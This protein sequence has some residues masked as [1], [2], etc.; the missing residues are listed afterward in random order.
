MSGDRSNFST[1]D[2]R[3]PHHTQGAVV[4]SIQRSEEPGRNGVRRLE[5]PRR[6]DAAAS[7]TKLCQDTVTRF[8][9]VFKDLAVVRDLYLRIAQVIPTST[10]GP[11]LTVANV[12]RSMSCPCCTK[13]RRIGCKLTLRENEGWNISDSGAD[14]TVLA[15]HAWRREVTHP[16]IANLIGFEPNAVRQGLPTVTASS[17]VRTADGKDILVRIHHAV[18]NENAKTSLISEYQV[19]HNDIVWDPIATTQRINLRGDTGTCSFYLGDKNEHQVL[20]TILNALTTFKSRRPTE[21]E[22]DTLPCFELTSPQ[23]WQP[24]MYNKAHPIFAVHLHALRMILKSSTEFNRSTVDIPTI[25]DHADDDNLTF[26]DAEDELIH[27]YDAEEDPFMEQHDDNEARQMVDPPAPAEVQ[28]AN[29]ADTRSTNLASTC[30]PGPS[31]A[32]NSKSDGSSTTSASSRRGRKPA[33]KKAGKDAK[34][35]RHHQNTN[36]KLPP[37]KTPSRDRSTSRSTSRSRSRSQGRNHPRTRWYSDEWIDFHDARSGDEEAWALT[38]TSNFSV[39]KSHSRGVFTEKPLKYYDT[40]ETIK[41]MRGRVVHLTLHKEGIVNGERPTHVRS[42]DVNAF[43]D[44][45]AMGELI[46]YH[47]INRLRNAVVDQAVASLAEEHPEM[48]RVVDHFV[49]AART[50]NTRWENFDANRLQLQFGT[51]N[52]DRIKK[53]FR[54]TTQDAVVIHTVPMMRGIAA[55]FRWLRYPRLRETICTDDIPAPTLTPK[56]YK[57]VVAFFGERSKMLNIYPY[58]Q[59]SNFAE[60]YK[61]F[62]KD[63]GIPSSLHSDNA[64]HLTGRIIQQLNRDWWTKASTTEPHHPWQNP[65][66]T[67]IVDRMKKFGDLVMDASGAPK[68]VWF[69]AWNLFAY[70]NNRI[71]QPALNDKTPIEKRH[72]QIPDISALLEFTFFEPVYYLERSGRPN[73]QEKAGY[74]LGPV[75][76][77]GDG[78]VYYIM[79]AD[80]DDIVLA[81]SVVRRVRSRVNQRA[82]HDPP[83]PD[84]TPAADEEIPDE[85]KRRLQELEKMFEEGDIP[86]EEVANHPPAD[87]SPPQTTTRREL[88]PDPEAPVPVTL[89]HTPTDTPVQAPPADVPPTLTSQSAT[90]RSL[91]R[92]FRSR[93]QPSRVRSEPGR[94]HPFLTING[95]RLRRPI[96]SDTSLPSQV[97]PL[98]VFRTAKHKKRSGHP[99]DQTP[100]TAAETSTS[101]PQGSPMPDPSDQSPREMLPVVHITPSGKVPGALPHS[102]EARPG[103][104]TDSG[105]ASPLDGC[106]PPATPHPATTVASGGA[107]LER[108]PLS[109]EV[110]TPVS[111]ADTT[112]FPSVP[113]DEAVSATPPTPVPAP[114][115]SVPQGDPPPDRPSGPRRSRRQRKTNQRYAHLARMATTLLTPIAQVSSILVTQAGPVY[116]PHGPGT[117]ITEQG[118]LAIRPSFESPL[119]MGDEEKILPPAPD[120]E[121]FLIR[122]QQLDLFTGDLDPNWQIIRVLDH[123]V[124]RVHSRTRKRI[125]TPDNPAPARR[126]VRVKVLFRNEETVWVDLDAVRMQDPL[127]L[128]LYANRRKLSSHQDWNWIKPFL[129]EG[130]GERLEELRLAFAV[131]ST[132]PHFQFGVEIPKYVAHAFEL[133]RRNNNHLWEEALKKELDDLNEYKTFILPDG[134]FD[135]TG[136]Q[137]INYTIVFACKVDGRRKARL[138]ANPTNLKQKPDRE[139]VYSGV[140]GMEVVRLGFTVASIHALE[141]AVGDVSSA[142]LYGKT[143]EKCYIIAGKEFGP[144]LEGKKLVIDRGLYGLATSAARYHE[145]MS[146]ELRKLGFRPT[147]VDPDLWMRRDKEHGYE[148]LAT[149]VDD[150]AV[151]SKNPM[152][153]L[154][155]LQMRFA[156][157]GVGRPEYYLGGNINFTHEDDP[158]HQAGVITTISARTYV[159]QALERL[160]KLLEI[161]EFKAAKT[162]MSESYHPEIDDSALLSEKQH[163]HYRAIIGSLNWLVTLGRL[164]IAYATNTLA[165]FSMAPREGHLTAAIRVI[166]YLRKHRDEEIKIDPR[167]FD[168]SSIE[169]RISPDYP[170]WKEFYPDAK[171]EIPEDAPPPIKDVQLS[172]Y[173]D[174]DHAHDVVT[175][176]SV[177]GIVLFINQTPV[178][179]ISK[180]QTTVET[181]TYGSEMVAARIATDLI[182]E[183]RY[184]LRMLGLNVNG[185]AWLFGDNM[186]VIL[187]TTMPSSGLKK[188]HLSIAYHRVRE[189]VA[190]RAIC[191]IHVDSDCNYADLMTKPLPLATHARL[192]E[193]LVG[194]RFPTDEPLIVQRAKEPKPEIDKKSLE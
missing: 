30:G 35:R 128:V 47:Y 98:Q 23:P 165:R 48:Q 91:V 177:T 158:W 82:P 14:T 78:I 68:E 37:V 58:K 194:R 59:K 122:L 76:H 72:G 5:E 159:G 34:R 155:D 28:V 67:Q 141:C 126:T 110:T 32:D 100:S 178:R 154:K 2:K 71:S 33:S 109:G 174:A 129:K 112:T 191:F 49:S 51:N 3:L 101:S 153:V 181:S 96:R 42:H 149:Y 123:A 4:N 79:T 8:E 19:R 73:S 182:I 7:F 185:P 161:P 43:L 97:V 56:G 124:K 192:M 61:E 70:V 99:S 104:H 103:N 80:K 139:E 132:A 38:H 69:Y 193:G 156:M 172:V 105:E 64:K 183:Y 53:T 63:E 13:N 86:T 164:D 125:Y 118:T 95:R 12:R 162:P 180:R 121:R 189:M 147:G 116:I 31:D 187:S 107:S 111:S 89:Q 87:G 168:Y 10:D 148:L 57:G 173:V 150:I 157:K 84:P 186:S 120:N 160:G 133:D 6:E 36:K 127:P 62:V 143:R 169:D 119:L 54:N 44:D 117:F 175:R 145:V 136:Y 27:Y 81:R 131:R 167:P 190:C 83:L 92:R 130:G 39:S 85:I 74:W 45:L 144:D 11:L 66:E 29:T 24:D 108:L 140:V 26:H 138:C 152:A 142:F 134:N 93:S 106:H 1:T 40:F 60:I 166:G 137:R 102:G 16:R 50:Q 15:P 171:E 20:M 65:L 46:P 146:E 55:R 113:Q 18:W 22:L 75:D 179:W 88:P 25:D 115:P 94:H 90:R 77:M 151:W 17:V 21:T 184:A 52:L 176:R 170:T 9:K 163:G 41:D 135:W 114:A 188:K